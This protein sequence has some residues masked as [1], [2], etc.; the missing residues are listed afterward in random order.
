M[1]NRGGR[2]R[3]GPLRDHPADA[4]RALGGVGLKVEGDYLCILKTGSAV[5]QMLAGTP[6]AG[7]RHAET[8]LRLPGAKDGGSHVLVPLEE[9]DRAPGPSPGPSRRRSGRG[10]G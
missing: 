1:P 3:D 10:F 4:A 2:R 5:E 9:L 7:G 8:L 6:W